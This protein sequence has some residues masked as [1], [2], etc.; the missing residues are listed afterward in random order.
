[1]GVGLMPAEKIVTTPD[2]DLQRKRD[3]RIAD[4]LERVHRLY[5]DFSHGLE[6]GSGDRAKNFAPTVKALIR[7]LVEDWV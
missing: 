7:D 3:A 1:M 4:R 5:L 6:H 2:Q